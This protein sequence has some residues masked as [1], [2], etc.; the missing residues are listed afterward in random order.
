[1]S[2]YRIQ[3]GPSGKN[4]Q[5][6]RRILEFDYGDLAVSQR[7]QVQRETAV[8]R[9]LLHKTAENV[10][11]IGLRLN[12]VH[13]I[14]GRDRFQG[15]LSAQFGWSQSTASNYMH[16]ARK[17]C[18]VK[19]L[20]QFQPS[21]LFELARRKASDEARAEALRRAQDGEIITKR[22]A[23]QIIRA[24]T[25]Q[26]PRPSVNVATQVCRTLKTIHLKIDKIRP[27][28]ADQVH[29]LLLDLLADV[30]KCQSNQATTESSLQ[31]SAQSSEIR[32]SERNSTHKRK[33]GRNP[34]S[35][36]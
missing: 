9:D 34:K 31:N 30:E 8:I 20:E 19:C 5:L 7:N 3:N 26:K 33:M 16:A 21:A 32:S 24:K 29:G 14:L 35:R 23:Q 11:Q 22:I 36:Q 18:E 13:G 4:G 15:W 10:I 28:D 25:L 1:M 17:F 12:G 6:I 27:A 2:N